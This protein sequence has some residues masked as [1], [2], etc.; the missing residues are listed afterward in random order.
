M[1]LASLN[2]DG[3]VAIVT[4]SGSGLGREMALG[5]AE[6][7]ADVVVTARTTSEIE[8]VAAEIVARGRR[9]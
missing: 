8:K 2:L 4:G 7:G 1:G 5:L 6:A 3:R 9:A